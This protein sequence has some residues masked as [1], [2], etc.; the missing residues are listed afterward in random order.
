MHRSDPARL[1]LA[2]IGAGLG[3]APHFQSLEDLASEVEVAWVYG[4]SAERLADLRTPTAVRKTTRLEDIFEDASVKAV[5][6]LTPP[7]SHLDIVQRAARAGKHVLVEKPLEIDLNRANALVEACEAAGV[8][9]A[10]MLQHRMRQAALGLTA[11]LNTGELGQLVSAAAAIRW[12]RPQSYYDEPGRGTLAR[13]G[14]GVLITQAIH[15][16]DLMLS[17]T[18][19]PERV[20]GLAMTSPV[21]RMEGED[22]AAALLHYAGGAVAVV[23]ATTAAYPGFPERIELN[24]TGG[25]ATLEAGELQAVFMNGKTVTLGTRQ[26]SG[27]GANPMGFDHAAHR[28]LL[29]DF[30]RAVQ[31]GTA[32]AVTGRSALGVQQVIEAIMESSKTGRTVALHPAAL[33]PVS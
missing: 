27:S 6:V 28:T 14:G 4:R 5:L 23:Q 18:G 2:V 19:L 17:F 7:N 11:L 30:I 29:Q 24:F 26:A 12:W 33:I 8:T 22:T 31:S 3:S 25:T 32:A 9:L 21:H 20:T 15:T 13:D 16:L 1:R 10:I